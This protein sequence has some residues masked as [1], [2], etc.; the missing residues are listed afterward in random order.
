M[1]IF[2]I[3]FLFLFVSFVHAQEEAVH[4]VYFEFD[5][6]DLQAKQGED[7]IA[8]IKRIVKKHQIPSETLE[9]EITET[10]AVLDFVNIKKILQEIRS[11][12]I[13]ISIDDFGTGYSSLSALHKFPI[14]VLKLDRSFLLSAEKDTNGIALLKLVILLAK[15]LGLDIVCE[16]VETKE[17]LTLLANLHCDYGQGYIFSRPVSEEI[18]R[19][20]FLK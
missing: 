9:I 1:R 13:G 3:L 2:Q 11:L 10:M 15:K 19:V 5:K 14:N 18:F 12:G 8:F 20:N 7:L 16:G 17:Q 4:S 6:F